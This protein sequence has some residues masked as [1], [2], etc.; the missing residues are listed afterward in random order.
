MVRF[1]LESMES[2]IFLAIKN[3]DHALLRSL[4]EKSIES[5]EYTMEYD[6]YGS[7]PIYYAVKREDLGS[8]EI[9]LASGISPLLP[10]SDGSTA[11]THLLSKKHPTI[12]PLLLQWL[13]RKGLETPLFFSRE[14][15]GSTLL[16]K[17][18]TAEELEWVE[19][20]IPC[21]DPL[22][23]EV[24][25]SDDRTP[26][27]WLARLGLSQ[28]LETLVSEKPSR[29]ALH[30]SDHKTPVYAACESNQLPVLEIFSSIEPDL[31]RK[32]LALPDSE[33][34]SVIHAAVASDAVEI[35]PFLF[36]WGAALTR[37]N[38]LGLTAFQIAD[39]D[40]LHHAGKILK[41]TLGDRIKSAKEPSSLKT[42]AIGNS[43][44]KTMDPDPNLDSNSDPVTWDGW[45][46]W[47]QSERIFQPEESA[48][49][50]LLM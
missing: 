48:R 30:G 39:R 4:L 17:W 10:N 31:F 3:Q 18:I 45:V 43:D 7:T 38:H 40:K 29:M 42:P 35:L 32:T 8:I 11:F 37:K 5:N 1:N 2:E 49:Y 6:R 12:S 34:N 36:E 9:L 25:D 20:L 23:W 13:K 24:C 26:I 47:A 15:D 21:I 33:G 19:E 16:H 14:K 22:A 41:K 44:R 50:G 27:H 28:L 46:R